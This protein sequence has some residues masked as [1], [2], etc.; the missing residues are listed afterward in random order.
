MK[1]CICTFLLILAVGYHS[2]A[3]PTNNT[4]QPTGKAMYKQISLWED[5][6]E[7]TLLFNENKSVYYYGRTADGSNL[8]NKVEKDETHYNVEIGDNEGWT[9]FKDI[10]TKEMLSRENIWTK[11]FIVKDTLR[12][13]QWKITDEAKK[14]GNFNCQKALC[15]FRGRDY[16]A[17]FTT[18][19]PISTGPWKFWGLP[20]LIVEAY[21]VNREYKFVLTAVDIPA[22]INT[23]IKQPH[24]GQL[25]NRAEFKVLYNKKMQ[26]L[27]K[28]FKAK[29]DPTSA[30]S[31]SVAVND[32]SI[33]KLDK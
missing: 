14:I 25:V 32:N 12:D 29:S 27:V 10:K 6:K 22:K 31:V 19:I 2:A 28:S 5:E 21:D 9:F 13:M 15:T 18:E 23:P 24:G 26:A 1:N 7:A 4:A 17:W 16:E 8:N 33:E 3:Q 30:G 11:Y 20:G